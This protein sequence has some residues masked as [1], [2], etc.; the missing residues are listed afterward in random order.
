M[1][2]SSL[3]ADVGAWS[4]EN[5]GDQPRVLPL[6][7]ICEELGEYCAANSADDELDALADI[8]I[9]ML[10]FCSRSSINLEYELVV[11]A[12][13]ARPRKFQQYTDNYQVNQILYAYNSISLAQRAVLKIEQGIRKNEDHFNDLCHAL[14]DLWYSCDNLA[15]LWGEAMASIVR[16]TWRRVVSKRSWTGETNPTNS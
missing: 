8:G 1:S 6:L 7:G 3:Q 15:S 12:P 13:R 2:L 14:V 9:F 4:R 5:F 16:K 11:R 10:D